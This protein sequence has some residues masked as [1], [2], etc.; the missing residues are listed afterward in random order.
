[1]RAYFAFLGE[2]TL[3]YLVLVEVVKRRLMRQLLGLGPVTL[4]T[5]QSRQHH[6]VLM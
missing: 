5:N 3:T 1:M 4:A 2:V 6:R